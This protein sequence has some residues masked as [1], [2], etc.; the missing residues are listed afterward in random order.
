MELARADGLTS[1]HGPEHLELEAVGILC[2]EREAHA[3][4]GL[5][6]QRADLEEPPAGASQVSQLADLPRRVIHARD[7]L[8]R[9]AD[10]PLLEQ[11]EVVIVGR[12]GNPEERAPGP[13][14]LHLEAEHLRVEAH[15]PLDVRHPQ[16]EMLQALEPEPRGDG[17]HH[18]YSALTVS[19]RH[20]MIPSPPG[21][22]RPPATAWTVTSPCG[23]SLR[24]RSTSTDAGSGTPTVTSTSILPP[25][26]RICRARGR[27][28]WWMASKAARHAAFVESPPWRSIPMPNSSS[29]ASLLMRRPARRRPGRRGRDARATSA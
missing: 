28:E 23:N 4:I 3:V 18:G 1:G 24:T 27:L 5:A 17:G 6:D 16:H 8:V 15:A 7:A 12:A 19:D 20:A 21:T 29:R 9:R 11:P 25:R 22:R 2:V 26:S 14:G 10:P 13:L